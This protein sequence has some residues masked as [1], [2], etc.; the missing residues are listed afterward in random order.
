MLKGIF[1]IFNIK[2]QR[3]KYVYKKIIKAKKYFALGKSTYMCVCFK[4]ATDYIYD[5]ITKLIPEFKPETFGLEPKSH[6]VP[7]W[8]GEDESSRFAAF[9]KLIDIYKTKL[10][11]FN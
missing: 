2:Y 8:P 6:K 11:K 5:D 4:H 10:E 9:D 3:T 7:W 1:R